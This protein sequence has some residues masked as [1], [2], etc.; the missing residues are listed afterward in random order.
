MTN[1]AEKQ[2]VQVSEDQAKQAMKDYLKL[3]A[4]MTIL[5]SQ[6]SLKVQEVENQFNPDIDLLSQRLLENHDLLKTYA[7]QNRKELFGKNQTI[8]F[9]GGQ[10]SFRKSGKKL[11]LIDSEKK[12]WEAVTKYLEKNYPAYIIKETKPDKKSFVRDFADKAASILNKIGV[13]IT[14]SESFS[15]K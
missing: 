6:K 12:D 2:A 15:I 4:K 1:V 14:S 8:D 10:L 7:E 5:E 13:K 3:V 11:E 9:E